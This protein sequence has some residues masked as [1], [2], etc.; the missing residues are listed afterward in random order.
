MPFS[1]HHKVFSLHHKV[2]TAEEAAELVLP[3]ELLGVSGF[4]LAGYPKT[5]PEAL[6][7]RGLRLKAAGEDFRVSVF[8]GASTGDELDGSLSRAGLIDWRMPYQSNAS[9][10]A[11]INEGRV[12]YLDVHLGMMGP[13]VRE[14]VLPKPTL[15]IVEAVAVTPEGRVYLSSS[16][17]NSATFLTL[18]DRIILEINGVYGDAF[19]GF[20]DTFLPGLPPLARPIPISNPADRVG[21]EYVQIDPKKIIAVVHTERADSVARFTEPDEVSQ[22]IAGHILDFIRHEQKKGRLPEGLPYQSGVGNVANAVLAAMAHDPLQGMVNLYTEVIQEAVFSLLEAGKLGVASGTA[23]TFSPAAQEIF[24][25]NVRSWK[26]R[27]VIRQQE[28]SNHA[29]VIRRLGVISMNTALECDIFGNVNSSHVSGTKIMNG[30]GGSADFARN[31]YL[32]F[33]MTP[34]TAKNGAVSSIVPLVSHVD[35]TEHDTQVFVTERGIADLR[36]KSPEEKAR[37]IIENC[38]HPNF[39]DLLNDYLFEGLKESKEHHL[40]VSLK[41]AFD[42]HLK[43]KE[44]GKMRES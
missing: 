4:T 41:N 11:Q 1:L 22:T 34:S 14:G 15:A 16:G 40:P 26:H 32:G 29:E 10:R 44:T 30:I 25:H 37:L 28:V 3:G 21:Q 18:A 12:R 31:C 8:S 7:K 33:F 35:H 13:M 23:L 6:A 20:H 27:F 39:K 2:M 19:I 17:G 38:A 43:F 5:V 9:L 36:G 24:K 42:V